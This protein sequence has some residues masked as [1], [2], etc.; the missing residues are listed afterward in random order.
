MRR[1]A[2]L[3]ACSLSG[4][5]F[6]AVTAAPAVYTQPAYESPVRGD[7]D[8]LLLIPG[9]GLAGDDTVVYQAVSDTTQLPSPPVYPPA[10]S[11]AAL[12]VAD[13][14]NTTGAP[15][16]LAVH[17]PAAMIAGQSYALWVYA[18]DG[19]HS[20]PILLND[21]RPLWITPD[22]AHSTAPSGGLSRVLKVVGRNLQPAPGVAATLIRL[23]G[24]NTGACYTLTAKN[25]NNDSVNTTTALERYVAEVNL[26]DTLEVDDYSVAVS[27]DGTSWVPLLGNGQSAAQIFTVDADPVAPATFAV[28]D[29]RFADPATGPCQP[30]DG[31]DDTACIMLA[32]RAATV[33]GG[34]TVVFGPGVWTMSNP[35]TWSSGV[36]F[37][38][39]LG[40]KAGKCVAPTET[41]GVSYYGVLVPRNVSLQGAGASTTT[42]ERGITWLNSGGGLVE[43]ALQGNNTVSGIQFVDHIDYSGGFAGAPMLQLGLRWY[44]AR[45]YSA[46][47]PVTVSNVVVTDNVFV[48]PYVAI[49]TGSLPTDH[50]FITNNTFG[51][52]W[53]T[54]IVLGQDR[55]DARNLSTTTTPVYPYTQYRF[56]DSVIAYNTFY[57]SSWQQ[58]AA[59]YASGNGGTMATQ[60]DTSL[61][62]DFSHNV[63][64]GTATQYLINPATDP[65]GWRAAHFWT[66]GANQELMLVSSNVV[67]CSG[68]KYGDGESLVFDAGGVLGGMPDDQPVISAVALGSAGTV[69]TIQ[70]TVV[71]TL[72][73]SNGPVDISANPAAYYKGFWIQVVQGKGEGQWRKVV[74]LATGSNSAGPTVTVRVTP[75]FDVLPDST[76]KVALDVAY[77]QQ[78]TVNNYVD[79]RTPTCTKANTRQG[80]I[81][82]TMS[83]YSSTADSVME[84][85]QQFDT[86]GIFVRHVY[87]PPTPPAGVSD[88]VG[89]AVQSMNEVRGNLIDGTYNRAN[90]GG[91]PGGLQLGFG[92]TQSWCTAGVCTL[93]PHPPE[94]GF[95]LTVA[96]NT[97]IQ[98]DARDVDGTVHPPVGAIGLNAGW[99]T[100]PLDPSG[101]SSWQMGDATLIFNNSLRNVHV[102]LGVDVAQGSTPNPAIN[103]HT[104]LYGNSCSNVDVPVSDFGLGTVRYCPAHAAGDCACATAAS[105]DVGLSASKSVTGYTVTITNHSATSAS[106]VTLTWEAPVGVSIAPGSLAASAGSCN[107]AV[108]ICNLGVLAGG[109]AAT[110]TLA[111]SGA[112]PVTFSVTHGESDP[113][114]GNDSTSL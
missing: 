62:L 54:A 56:N 33:A 13:L 83:W 85:N 88:H 65:R 47:D 9:D 99:N 36:S 42:I 18:A 73:N 105:A 3:C 15:H 31:I 78:L 41:C 89:L 64:D 43:F 94:L 58:T 109:Q 5:P 37:S 80:G 16:S 51:G 46:T 86:T 10:T 111:S 1:F 101:A 91:T 50:V 6:G 102:G 26:P 96:A 7:P 35:G 45:L 67:T 25:A 103:W 14:A 23:V 59:A 87:I 68:D 57:P 22:S 48:R 75:A 63:A 44:F 40:T 55:N 66:R 97:V 93:A 77:W 112:G 32:I 29:P 17:L 92:A 39:R 19:T 84:G 106:S 108:S 52:A 60:L 82:G 53:S 8:D 98:A 21:A 100:G 76:S 11:N 2:L 20:S 34:G 113:C 72:P 79:Q 38:N 30:D 12:G 107:S 69:L 95:G 28:S 27:R 114:A 90:T 104:T 110:V 74:A 61:H 4:T 70:G 81:G 71:T 24:A 49:G